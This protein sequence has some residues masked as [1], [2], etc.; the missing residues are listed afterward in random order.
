MRR[1]FYY[2]FSTVILDVLRTHFKFVSRFEFQEQHLQNEIRGGNKIAL[3]HPLGLLHQTE[4][5][6]H[7]TSYHPPRR[8]LDGLRIKIK[9]AANSTHHIRIDQRF[10]LIQPL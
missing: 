1:S 8:T 7:A 10:I 2:Y 6:L 9:S 3:P 4:Q 5:P